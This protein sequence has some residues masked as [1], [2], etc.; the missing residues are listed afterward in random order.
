[1]PTASCAS[2]QDISCFIV[3]H[4]SYLRHWHRVAEW[5]YILG[6]S[7]RIVAVD[8]NGKQFAGDLLGPTA[9]R[10]GDIYV[11][12]VGGKLSFSPW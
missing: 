5:G 4:A 10:E 12:P 3:T 1:M 6:G 7:G 11:F 9:D 8:E 2:F